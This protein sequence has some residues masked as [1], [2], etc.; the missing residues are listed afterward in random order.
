MVADAEQRRQKQA[1]AASA[2]EPTVEIDGDTVPISS[3]G[4]DEVL[5]LF[6]KMHRY[7]SITIDQRVELAMHLQKMQKAQ[8]RKAR[9]GA[10]NVL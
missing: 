1:G 5:D 2:D 6:T 8:K 4:I 9:E 7:P 3:L 10:E